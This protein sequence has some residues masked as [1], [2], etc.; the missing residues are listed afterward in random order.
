YHLYTLISI[1]KKEFEEANEYFN[2]ARNIFESIGASYEISKLELT[3]GVLAYAVGN[4]DA[5]LIY[6]REIREDFKAANMLYQEGLRELYIAKTLLE[7][8]KKN[9]S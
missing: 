4:Y 8:I 1:E 3:G 9:P 6:L 7:F 5:A 2:N